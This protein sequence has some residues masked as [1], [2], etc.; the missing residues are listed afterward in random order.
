MSESASGSQVTRRGVLAA[1]GAALLGVA[2]G[3]AIAVRGEPG[4]SPAPAP[5][6]P[7]GSA[8]PTAPS[9]PMRTYAF[10]GAHQAGIETPPTLLQTFIGLDLRTPGLDTGE[11]ALRLITDDA[12]RLT[13]GRP[14]L[15]DTEETLAVHP[16]GLTIAVGLGR[17][18][19]ERIGLAERMPPQLAPIPEFST[20][21]FEEPWVQ[22]DLVLQVGSDDA[23]TLAHAIRM[24]TKDLSTLT[25]VRWMQPGFR[26]AA[27]ATPD[28]TSTRNLMGQ[29]DGTINPAAG[30]AGFDEVVWITDGP[31]WVQ[32]GT[33]LILRRIR[34]LLDEWEI[35]DRPA[36]EAAI[37]RQLSTGAPLGRTH[38]FDP[39]PFDERDAN[40]LPIIPVDSHIAVAHARTTREM[41]LRRPYNYDNGMHDG[42]N[43]VG[44]LFAAYT[45]D[46]SRSFIPMQQRIATSDAFNKWNTTIGSAAYLFPRGAAEGEILAEGLFA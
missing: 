21:A 40:G 16:E 12:A 28:S 46:P 7:T 19:F 9:A 1:G 44:L 14:A 3:Y 26:S 8:A 43:D 20:D 35:L 42:T 31:D 5:P 36:Q 2:G 11:A 32:G 18:F 30:T 6:Q 27:P 39:V 37:G 22:T 23:V 24:L 29:V 41:I 17:P 13:Q 34:M 15:G 38:E 45:A 25:E 33:V 10:H 4:G